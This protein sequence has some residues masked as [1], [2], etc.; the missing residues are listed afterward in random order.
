MNQQARYVLERQFEFRKDRVVDG[1]IQQPVLSGKTHRDQWL[2]LLDSR[3]V[4]RPKTLDVV[5]APG[6]IVQATI[7]A[8]PGRLWLEGTPFN[9]LMFYLSPV[10]EVR[11]LREGRSFASDMQR[12]EMTLLP[13]GV[14]SHWSWSS[15]GNR[16]DVILSA[17][18]F[19]DG[20]ELNVVDRFLFRD[21][22]VEV[23]CYRLHRLLSLS[24]STEWI[25]VESL[26]IELAGL[27]LRHYSTAPQSARILPSSRLAD[28]QARRVLDYIESNLSRAL[29]LSELARVTDLSLHHFARLFKKTL[30]M[31]P[32][33]YVLKRR[34]ENAKGM[35]RTADASLVDISLSL[36]FSSQSHFTSAFHRLVGATPTQFQTCH[37]G[38]RYEP[39]RLQRHREG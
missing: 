9:V 18:V 34:V 5:E 14:P 15:T 21:H 20:R 25:S 17:D 12:G 3:G 32:H 7:G 39:S 37:G 13:R 1:M 23:I 19:E 28:N 31:A 26:A 2:A 30:G 35:L 36:G 6:A 11:Q 24:G 27:L 33:R 10:R 16:L 8:P 4:G 29:S 22:E 38:R